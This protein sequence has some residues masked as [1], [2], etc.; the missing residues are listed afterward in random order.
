MPI[1]V[2]KN[3]QKLR[4]LSHK[5]YLGLIFSHNIF[6]FVIILLP[7]LHHVLLFN[8]MSQKITLPSGQI[9]SYQCS[10]EGAP[11]ILLHGWGCSLEIFNSLLPLLGA[12]YKIYAIDFPGFGASPEPAKIEG[13]EGYT[14]FLKEFIEAMAIE[15]PILVG[16]SFGCR[17]AIQYASENSV[18]KMILM[19]AAGVKPKRKAS[20]YIKVYSYKFI[21]K[22]VLGV[23]GRKRG[24]KFLSESLGFGG[25]SDYRS[26]SETMRGVLSRVVNEDL[27]H[28]MPKVKC[29]TL[30][31]FGA[32]DTAT[33]PSDGRVMESLIPDAGLLVVQGAGHYVFLDRADIV[34]AA[35]VSFLKL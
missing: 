21:K 7:P 28:L 23:M 29:S 8:R 16:H 10:G 5:F 2:G 30:L 22:I 12:K 14:T 6:T 34:R 35:F 3:L 18:E 9:I 17:V 24:Y 26:S 1:K 13:V 27:K 25:S 15:N 31:I 11:L 20:Y 32:T 19:G 4:F 33:P